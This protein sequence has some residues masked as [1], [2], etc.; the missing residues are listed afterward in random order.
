MVVGEL[1]APRRCAFS[2]GRER[3]SLRFLGNRFIHRRLRLQRAYPTRA[4]F[5]TR[6]APDNPGRVPPKNERVRHLPAFSSVG[7]GLRVGYRRRGI[8]LGLRLDGGWIKRNCHTG[9]IP[10]GASRK[11][12]GP[13]RAQTNHRCL[14]RRR[15]RIGS[16]QWRQC[17]LR[18]A[19]P[20]IASDK[21][22]RVRVDQGRLCSPTAGKRSS[23]NPAP[24]RRPRQDPFR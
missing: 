2:D 22:R 9:V 11:L 16:H 14:V 8:R 5:A 19:R 12:G 7:Q 24:R 10:V 15:S 17:L 1:F 4:A 13:S 3:P 18:T 23:P 6:R 20:S 21:L